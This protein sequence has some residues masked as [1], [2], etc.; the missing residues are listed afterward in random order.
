MLQ[1]TNVIQL[2]LVGQ[3]FL[4]FN[5][6]FFKVFYIN[7]YLDLLRRLLKRSETDI[8]VIRIVLAALTVGIRISIE[9]IGVVLAI[10]QNHQESRIAALQPF[11]QQNPG[12]AVVFIRGID[13]IVLVFREVTQQS[14]STSCKSPYLGPRQVTLS[15]GCEEGKFL[16]IRSSLKVFSLVGFAFP[17]IFLRRGFFVVVKDEI[18][19]LIRQKPAINR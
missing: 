8:R 7:T 3:I 16:V 13:R 18:A 17:E 14:R 9:G 2:T 12:S 11:Q 19:P 4:L 1:L 6:T 15:K 5:Y 10:K